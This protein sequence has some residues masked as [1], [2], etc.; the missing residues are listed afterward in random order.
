MKMIEIDEDDDRDA[1]IED[2]NWTDDEIES[3]CEILNNL[4]FWYWIAENNIL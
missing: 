3:D 4:F 1:C 2:D